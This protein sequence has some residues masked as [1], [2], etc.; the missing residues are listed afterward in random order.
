MRT[1]GHETREILAPS[2]SCH[3][4]SLCVRWFL[5]LS[6]LY[7]DRAVSLVP[8]HDYDRLGVELSEIYGEMDG[9]DAD[10]HRWQLGDRDEIRSTGH[11]VKL[12]RYTVGGAEALCRRLDVELPDYEF[13]P[14]KRSKYFGVDWT[15][16][17]G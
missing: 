9:V 10:F 16:V 15:G 13:V 12:T 14:F 4:W 8:D 11:L 5:M 7:Y 1:S 2:T 6:H 3:S 17:R